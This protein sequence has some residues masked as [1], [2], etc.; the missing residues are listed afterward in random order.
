MTKAKASEFDGVEKFDIVRDEKTNA[1]IDPNFERSV[2]KQ[3]RYDFSE[4]EI[5]E[6]TKEMV[7][8]SKEVDRLNNA[9]AS[10]KAQYK[11]DIAAAEG[12]VK[13]ARNKIHDGFEYRDMRCG[14]LF[15]RKTGIA[16]QV[17]LADGIVHG[18]RKLDSDEMLLKLD[19][20]ERKDKAGRQAMEEGE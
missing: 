11:A 19:T 6:L 7:T 3:C 10:I 1:I 9:L 18:Q 16:V 20:S 4:E 12:V 15:D 2:L 8:S 13:S 5:K 17:R 14:E